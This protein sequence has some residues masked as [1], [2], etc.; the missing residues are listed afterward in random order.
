MVHSAEGKA[1]ESGRG[2]KGIPRNSGNMALPYT[3][4]YL[5]NKEYSHGNT[6]FFPS[7]GVGRNLVHELSITCSPSFSVIVIVAASLAGCIATGPPAPGDNT[8]WNVSVI[9]GSTTSSS[10]S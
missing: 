1:R 6:I 10:I 5:S 2:G 3:F 8:S 7:G 9:D 4:P